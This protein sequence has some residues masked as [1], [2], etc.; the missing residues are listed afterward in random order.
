M[1]PPTIGIA[2]PAILVFA[3]VVDLGSRFVPY[4]R[5]SFR[6]F[7]ALTRDGGEGLGG[8]FARNAKYSNDKAYGDLSSMG[9][10]TDLRQY[11]T[12][13][14]TTD[15]WGFRNAP[16]QASQELGAVLFGSSFAAGSGL[17]DDQT[18]SARLEQILGAPVY[19]AADSDLGNE[20][21]LDRL[22]S[23][24]RFRRR[25]AIVEHMEGVPR[26]T[27][28]PQS[29]SSQQ[30]M[31]NKLG[32]AYR[33][34]R[35]SYAYAR[36]WLRES[37]LKLVLFKAF[38]SIQDDVVLPNSFADR[39]VHDELAN[40]DPILFLPGQVSMPTDPSRVADALDFWRQL[41]RFYRDRTFELVVVLVPS[42]YRVYGPLLAH[43]RPALAGDTYIDDLARGLQGAGITVINLKETMERA[44]RDGLRDHHYVYWRDDTHWNADGVEL[45]AQEIASQ[46]KRLSAR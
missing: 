5:V 25:L 21:E 7:E 35:L 20:H 18:L 17:S 22:I 24:L 15:D 39:V 42:Q 31:E 45:A 36:G 3:L 32:A 44:A 8:P 29:S 11:R 10:A 19:N 13:V 30:R 1:K 12:E 33:P 34:L 37:P 38:K 40:G 16:N 6:A 23:R 4:E 2:A 43:P 27:W 14:V 28:T 46:L 41:K 26:P 9:N